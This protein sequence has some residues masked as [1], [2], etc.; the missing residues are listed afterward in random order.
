MYQYDI[1]TILKLHDIESDDKVRYGVKIVKFPATSFQNQPYDSTHQFLS[2]IFVPP[3][4]MGREI[5][6]ERQVSKHT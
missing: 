4:S 1:D 6:P 3:K 5:S 2:Y